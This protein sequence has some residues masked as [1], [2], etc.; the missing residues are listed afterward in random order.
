MPRIFKTVYF[1]DLFEVQARINLREEL[2]RL[3]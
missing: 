2:D 3:G 1:R